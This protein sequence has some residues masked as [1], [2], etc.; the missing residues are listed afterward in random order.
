MG[1]KLIKGD[2]FLFFLSGGNVHIHYLEEKCYDEEIFF[3]HLGCHQ[4]VSVGE[5]LSQ[6]KCIFNGQREGVCLIRCLERR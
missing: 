2:L 5:S 3:Y 4:W 1:I 6:R